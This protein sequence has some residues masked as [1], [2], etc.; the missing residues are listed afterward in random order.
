MAKING[1]E[2]KSKAPIRGTKNGFRAV[3]YMDNSK[4]GTITNSDENGMLFAF[5]RAEAENTCIERMND[6]SKSLKLKDFNLT[7]FF[8]RLIEL[9]EVEKVFKNETHKFKRGTAVFDVLETQKN[10]E[11]GKLV[12]TGA[13]VI[14][15]GQAKEA[16][17]SIRQKN[18]QFDRVNVFTSMKDFEIQ[19]NET[20]PFSMI[21]A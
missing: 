10:D 8:N 20:K 5:I 14:R 2:I 4:I 15:K 7:D 1:V 6:Y 21:Y 12:A 9:N 17:K 16:V 11:N 19:T 18:I 3:L 13:F